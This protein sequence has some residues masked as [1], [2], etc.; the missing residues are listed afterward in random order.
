MLAGLTLAT[1]KPSEDL[2]WQGST[3]LD[4]RILFTLTKVKLV[5]RFLS[6]IC[7]L[8]NLAL[9]LNSCLLP[10]QLFCS[11]SLYCT[12]LSL[13]YLSRFLPQAW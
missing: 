13:L 5:F 2:W 9:G 10:R 1:A 8:P 6:S 7:Q 3:E 12:Y 11:F 4:Y